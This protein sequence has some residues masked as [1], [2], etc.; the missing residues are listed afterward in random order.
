MGLFC[1]ARLYTYLKKLIF[2]IN[3]IFPTD[4]ISYKKGI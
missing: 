4:T 1:V 2:L 3:L